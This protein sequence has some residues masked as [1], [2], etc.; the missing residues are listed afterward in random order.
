MLRDD[1]DFDDLREQLI[2]RRME[3]IE[4]FADYAVN[5]AGYDEYTLANYIDDELVIDALKDDIDVNGS[6]R[7]QE[8][9]W[10]D[11][12]EHELDNGFFAYRID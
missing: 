7:G 4:S 1:I 6:G 11:G 5:E 8:I 9:S 2:D 3:D 10:Y 12:E